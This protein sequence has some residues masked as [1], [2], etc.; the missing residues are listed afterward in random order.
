MRYFRD[1]RKK[2]YIPLSGVMDFMD[3]QPAAVRAAYARIVEAV[4]TNGFAVYPYAEKVEKDLFAMRI[5]SGGN[6][7]VFYVYMDGDRVFGIHAYEK[8]SGRIPA[9]ELNK[10]RQTAKELLS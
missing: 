6:V 1:M 3:R 7:R 5:K 4:E 8:K 10:A 2:I 9:R